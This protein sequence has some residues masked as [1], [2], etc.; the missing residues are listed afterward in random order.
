MVPAGISA[1]LTNDWNQQMQYAQALPTI[2]GQ[3]LP[4]ALLPR[5]LQRRKKFSKLK[6]AFQ[7]PEKNQMHHQMCLTFLPS[8]NSLINSNSNSNSN[9]NINNKKQR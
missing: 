6:Q 5:Q 9:I 7:G 4:T 8:Y 2:Q 1:P 3:T